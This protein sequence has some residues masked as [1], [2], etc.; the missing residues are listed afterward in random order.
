[1]EK[2]PEA[3]NVDTAAFPE[4]H[5]NLF[6]FFF[7]FTVVKGKPTEVETCRFRNALRMKC[8]VE[9]KF[10]EA[11]WSCSLHAGQALTDVSGLFP[12]PDPFGP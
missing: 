2:P 1:M 3:K 11:W 10:P 4:P 7:F 12:L 8:R 5:L 6:F 9:L